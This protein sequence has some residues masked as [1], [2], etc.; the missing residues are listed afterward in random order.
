MPLRCWAT[1]VGCAVT[2]LAT[3]LRG[4]H[5]APNVTRYRLANGID[6]I[7]A[8]EPASARVVVDIWYRSGAAAEKVGQ[9]GWAHLVEHVLL[10][11]SQHISKS[12]QNAIFSSIGGDRDGF[13]QLDHAGLYAAAAA[14]QLET[15]LWLRS[16][17][18]GFWA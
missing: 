9:E 2:F 16:D 18:V 6:V 11:G 13:T 8:P 15:L 4:D 3:P 12:E 7:L 17:Q 1:I 14:N 5:L 10:R